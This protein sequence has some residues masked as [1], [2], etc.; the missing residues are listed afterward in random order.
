MKKSLKVFA[1]ACSFSLVLGLSSCSNGSDLDSRENSGSSS[2]ETSGGTTS[3]GTT[4]GGATTGG[5]TTG[6]GTSGT[7]ITSQV[8]KSGL[9]FDFS[10]AKAIAAVD[11]ENSGRAAYSI[12]SRAATPDSSVD[13][14]PLLK[15]LED[16]K[17]ESALTLADNAN[18]ANI[19][20]IYKSPLEG[21]N[22]IFIVFDGTSSFYDEQVTV[23]ENGKTVSSNSVYKTLGQLVCIHEDNTIA[24]ILKIEGSTN[25]YDTWQ[26]YLS[27]ETDKGVVFDAAGNLY[28]MA[29]KWNSSGDMSIVYKFDPKTNE[30]TELT[31]SVSGTNYSSFKITKDGKIIFV[32]GQRDG[33]GSSATFLRAIPVDDPNNFSSIYYSSG[34]SWDFGV[35][36]W[37]Y[38]EKNEVIYYVPRD[39]GLYK[40]ERSGNSFKTGE[41]LGTSTGSELNA[42]RYFESNYIYVANW[43]A[44]EYSFNHG[45]GDVSFKLVDAYGNL[46]PENAVRCIIEYFANFIDHKSDSAKDI[47]LTTAEVDIRFDVFKNIEGY[48]D[49]YTATKGLKNA[50]VIKALDTFKLRNLLHDVFD[51]RHG[52]YGSAKN[53][54]SKTSVYKHN[55][56]ADILYVKGTDTLLCNSDEPVNSSTEVKGSE[57]FKKKGEYYLSWASLYDVLSVPFMQGFSSVWDKNDN[58]VFKKSDGSIDYSV[59]L[60]DAFSKCY[61]HGEKEFRLDI[62]KDDET[63]GALYSDLTDEE[64]LKWI[65]EDDERLF[66]FGNAF[67]GEWDSAKNFTDLF[68]IKGTNEPA[69]KQSL[70]DVCYSR[71]YGEVIKDYTVNSDGSLWARYTNTSSS[72]GSE[73]KYFYFVQITDSDGC[74]IND[75]NEVNLPAGKVSQTIENDGALYMKYSLLDSNGGES[76]FH[77]IYKVNFA[78]GAYV[79]MF[80]NVPNN[81]K[82]EVISYSVGADR[83][84]YSAVR[85]TSVENGVVSTVTNEYN[86]LEIT[87]KLSAIYT[88]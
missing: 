27:L 64:A 1:F 61:T 73:D 7:H 2:G 30:I 49:I 24:D 39:K 74:L 63:Y 77:Q 33:S 88:F 55:F 15:I 66:W 35:L 31:A 3:G 8:I 29:R 10:N 47:H 16:G 54:I 4:T 40:A 11:K 84:Y 75:F 43:S 65:I 46:I 82:L 85:G 59:I 28:Y 45:N 60:K 38:D 86:P 83:L 71:N 6:G 12:N 56:F 81:E 34:N 50:E 17:F 58:L 80:K 19:K 26:N 48:E 18:L 23:D 42:G 22:D 37:V 5:T 57:Y 41:L 72:G 13:D 62:F 21:S 79:N 25:S 51:S 52:Y 20:E 32:Q 68:F 36:D 78:D 76:G 9:K 44:Q 70:K 67:S 53:Y 87:K 14:S 69:Y